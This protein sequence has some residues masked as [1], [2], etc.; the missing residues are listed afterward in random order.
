MEAYEVQQVSEVALAA[1]VHHARRKGR[2]RAQL[3]PA[4]ARGSVVHDRAVDLGRSRR[5]LAKRDM[6]GFL[7]FYVC[8]LNKII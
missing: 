1:D 8:A 4:H 2:A 3:E 7:R 5:E 6:N